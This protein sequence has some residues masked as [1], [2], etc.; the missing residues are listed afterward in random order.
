MHVTTTKTKY[1]ALILSLIM[2]AL[3]CAPVAAYA[4]EE[5]ALEGEPMAIETTIRLLL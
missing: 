3:L 4:E 1:L 5:E 2:T